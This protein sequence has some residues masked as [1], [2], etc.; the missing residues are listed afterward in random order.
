MVVRAGVI[1][2]QNIKKIKRSSSSTNNGDTIITIDYT[3]VD[4]LKI[5]ILELEIPNDEIVEHTANVV[6]IANTENALSSELFNYAINNVQIRSGQET[7]HP[8]DSYESIISDRIIYTFNEQVNSDDISDY[9]YGDLISKA[10]K[11]RTRANDSITERSLIRVIKTTTEVVYPS[12][13]YL[14]VLK[15]LVDI[16]GQEVAFVNSG[17][18]IGGNEPSPDYPGKYDFFFFLNEPEKVEDLYNY[19]LQLVEQSRTTE[20]TSA[21]SYIVSQQTR[22]TRIPYV[23]TSYISDIYTATLINALTTTTFVETANTS[24]V[25]TASEITTDY[26]YTYISQSVNLGTTIYNYNTN[27]YQSVYINT[28]IYNTSDS[29][30]QSLCITDVIINIK[31]TFN[32]TYNFTD[33]TITRSS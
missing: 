5:N 9:V 4:R 23:D 33:T 2:L 10:F 28:L 21:Y 31:N 22:V 29:I 12:D 8:T 32:N 19:I 24:D 1:P 17:G 20:T 14:R 11:E 7:S 27:V 3:T 26:N 25:I 6:L 16:F 15:S 18:N 30:A 13:T